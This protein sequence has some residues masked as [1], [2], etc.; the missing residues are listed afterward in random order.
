MPNDHFTATKNPH[1]WRPG[2]P[3]LDSITYKPIPD[4][5]QLLAS[6]QSGGVDIMHT[7]T[8]DVIHAAPGAT[9]PSA[10]STTRTRWPA[11]RTWAASCS[12]CPSR[13]FDNLKVRQATAYAVSS[14]QY[15]QVIDQGV[16]PTSNGPFTTTSPYYVADNGY[17]VYNPAK[18]TQL[19]KEV[20]QETGQ[21]VSVTLNH[22]PDPSTTKIAEY[23][24][25]QLQTVGMTVTLSPIQQAQIIN[26]ALLGTFEAQLWRQFGAVDPDLNYIF[27]SPTNATTP[28]FSINMA[29]N[30]DPAMETALLKGRQSANHVGPGRR[31]PGGQQAAWAR[32]SPTSGTTGRSGPSAPSPRCRTSPTR[33]PRPASKAFALIGGAIWPTQIWLNS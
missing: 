11:S 27:W 26:T 13:P 30:T 7:D 14:A 19:V 15:V 1:Y 32:T 4:P 20:Q 12:T 6:L 9:P 22:T 18:A 5:D 8:A 33:P 2:L 28:G 23:L 29:R 31:L 21:P 16:N 24:Q 10:T 17:P 25:Q 3:Y